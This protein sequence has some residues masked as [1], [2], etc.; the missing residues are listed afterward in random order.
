MSL[1]NF[2]YTIS[3]CD[4]RLFT[5]ETGDIGAPIVIIPATPAEVGKSELLEQEVCA[6]SSSWSIMQQFVHFSVELVWERKISRKV[7][8]FQR[9]AG[10]WEAHREP[11][12][13]EAVDTS[14]CPVPGHVLVSMVSSPDD[15]YQTEDRS[16][17]PIAM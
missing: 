8:L 15:R 13:T 2:T 10:T 5:L 4:G 7:L 3:D 11:A 12:Y 1:D 9:R 17:P 6:D 16:L 14:H